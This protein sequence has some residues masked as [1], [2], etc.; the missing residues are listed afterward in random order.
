V[1]VS[2]QRSVALPLIAVV[3]GV[4]WTIGLMV[5]CGSKINMGR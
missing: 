4:V 1:G 3:I 2:H 5:L